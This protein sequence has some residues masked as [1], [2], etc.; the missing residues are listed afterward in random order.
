MPS[1]ILLPFEPSRDGFAFRNAF[2]WT[3]TDLTFLAQQY[4]TLT[5]GAVGLV[6]ALGGGV[7]GGPLGGLLGAGAA[8]AFGRAGVADGLLRSAVQRWPSFGLCGG[9]ALTAIE[10]WPGTDRVPTSALELEPM[11]ALLW[12]RQQRTLDASLSTFARFWA[13]VRFMPGNVPHAPFAQDLC[14]QLDRIQ[15]TLSGGRPA[16]IGL[17]GDAPDPF[18]LHQVVVFG[19]ERRGEVS[20]TLSVYDP[21]AP[22]QTRHI[23]TRPAPDRRRTCLT[24]DMPTGPMP[25]GRHHISTRAGELSHLFQIDI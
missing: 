22:G 18:A 3:E 16:L 21:N 25:T 8:G 13:R 14:R 4:R 10:R 20:A 23:V 19:I 7:V 11:R 1:L 2:S 9:M 15:H 17:V 24:T 5:S 6:G 12:R